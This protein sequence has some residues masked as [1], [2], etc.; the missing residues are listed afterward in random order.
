MSFIGSVLGGGGQQTPPPRQTQPTGPA[1]G[2]DSGNQGN[3]AG[4]G[5]GGVNAPQETSGAD[6]GSGGATGGEAGAGGKAPTT[7]KP[8]PYVAA[9][10]VTRGD[11]KA[12]AEAEAQAAEPAADRL[13]RAFAPEIAD[14]DRARGFAEAAQDRDA[15]ARLI[16]AIQP[17]PDKAPSLRE[18]AA[19]VRG[20]VKPEVSPKT[21]A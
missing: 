4:S 7:R 13:D 15:A 19:T 21:A 3:D 10:T 5:T 16:A 18:D 6:A 11:V 2:A 1:T 20:F 17:A 12:A 8:I 14:A 9:P